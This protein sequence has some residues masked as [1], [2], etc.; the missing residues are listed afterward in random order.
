[1]P[2]KTEE[3]IGNAN[4]RAGEELRPQIDQFRF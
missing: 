3:V 4:L 2:A 1:M